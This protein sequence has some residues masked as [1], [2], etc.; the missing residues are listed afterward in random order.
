MNGVSDEYFQQPDR[1]KILL[2]V[3]FIWAEENPNTAGYRQGMHEIVAPLLMA[4]E[5]ERYFWSEAVHDKSKSESS[6]NDGPDGDIIP[7]FSNA[8][9]TECSLYWLFDNIMQDLDYLYEPPSQTGEQPGVVQFCTQVQ[10]KMLRALDPDLCRHLEEN[11]V[12]AQLYGMRWSRLLLGREFDAVEDG[13]FRIW[14]YIFASS[15]DISSVSKAEGKP[16]GKKTSDDNHACEDSLFDPLLNTPNHKSAEND[17]DELTTASAAMK[18]NRKRFFNKPCPIL[19][20]L[21]DF[22]LAMLLHIRED[23]LNGDSSTTLQL[24]MRYPPV[25]DITPIIDLADMIRRGVLNANSHVGAKTTTVINEMEKNLETNNKVNKFTSW[26][27]SE[28]LTGLSIRKNLEGVTKK[29]GQTISSVVSTS[30]SAFSQDE[31]PHRGSKPSPTRRVSGGTRN[32]LF[33][34]S[35][36]GSHRSGNPLFDDPLSDETSPVPPRQLA[37]LRCDDYGDEAMV[38]LDMTKNK[39]VSL[40]NREINRV[41][42]YLESWAAD[43]SRQEPTI[44][45]PNIVCRLRLITGLLESSLSPEEYSAMYIDNNDTLVYR[46][47]DNYSEESSQENNLSE[48]DVEEPRQEEVKNGLEHESEAEVFGKDF[49]ART[50][51][52]DKD[53]SVIQPEKKEC[54]QGDTISDVFKLDNKD[55]ARELSNVKKKVVNDGDIDSIFSELAGIKKKNVDKSP[56]D[57]PF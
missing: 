19:E 57:D 41:A 26:R 1:A 14:D 7:Y 31:Q 42:A 52:L 48:V 17:E 21:A 22:M 28:S 50:F 38:P 49:F 9:Y 40:V 37:D 2:N 8:K 45:M 47:N 18:A 56:F 12:Q 23:L 5:A 15:L 33:G 3:L 25:D 53:K 27:D 13:L 29:V 55:K 34:I 30:V 6:S 39:R 51:G 11:Y 44:V 10:E 4:L 43:E 32:S 36:R 46:S 24:L 54:E 20:S 35:R 16:K